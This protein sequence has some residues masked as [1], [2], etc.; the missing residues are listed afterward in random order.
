MQAPIFAGLWLDPLVMRDHFST[1]AE[2]SVGKG[3]VDT[4]FI[5]SSAPVMLDERS[6]LEVW[7]RGLMVHYPCRN[8]RMRCGPSFA[9][10]RQHD[11]GNPSSN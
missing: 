1:L 5:A 10:A 7:S 11:S 8:G 2:V 4:A 6:D 3:N 9:R